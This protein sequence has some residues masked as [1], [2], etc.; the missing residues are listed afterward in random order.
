MS[1]HDGSELGADQPCFGCGPVHPIGFHLSFEDQGDEVLTR[2]TPGADHQGPPGIMH[3]G[4]VTTLADELA[5]WTVLLKVGKFGFTTSLQA[6]LTH[7]VRIGAPVEGRGRLVG[8][9]RRMVDV[10][11]T[12]WQAEREVYEAT[13]RFALLDRAAAEKLLGGP[14]PDRWVNLAR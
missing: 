6:R 11:V 5:A 4:L 13:F 1:T 14:L 9:P 10:A 3:G 8:S 7:A 12:L 2:Y